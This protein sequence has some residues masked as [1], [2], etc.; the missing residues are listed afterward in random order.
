MSETPEPRAENADADAWWT[1]PREEAY[2]MVTTGAGLGDVAEHLGI[3]T[4]TLYDWRQHPLWRARVAK[5][6]AER[7]E[8]HED[9][10]LVVNGKAIESL[11][12]HVET[13]APTNLEYLHRRGILP[14]RDGKPES[15]KRGRLVRHKGDRS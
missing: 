5:D 1:G 13:H 9:V 8:A 7:Q 14:K 6:R 2:S 3:T 4:R 11:Q 15:R 10:L 12:T